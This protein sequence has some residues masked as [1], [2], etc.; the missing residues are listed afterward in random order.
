M[1]NIIEQLI[2]PFPSRGDSMPSL[3]ASVKLTI[4]WS[5][6]ITYVV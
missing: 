2:I 3:I 5:A 6:T 1:E 4:P